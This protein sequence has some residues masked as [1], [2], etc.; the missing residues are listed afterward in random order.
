MKIR[1]HKEVVALEIAQR[2]R[3]AAADEWL[4][5]LE[6]DT[7]PD[8]VGMRTRLDTRRAA[9]VRI[10]DADR[11]G[12]VVF[13]IVEHRGMVPL[14]EWGNIASVQVPLECVVRAEPESCEHRDCGHFAVARDVELRCWC[15]RHG[16]LDAQRS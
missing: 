3:W 14:R 4:V 13:E 16:P 10:I 12:N 9:L 15:D 2:L 11:G 5:E 7:C 6:W 1:T 8:G